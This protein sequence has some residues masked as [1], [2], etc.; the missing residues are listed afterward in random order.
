MS[1]EQAAAGTAAQR[2]AT[3]LGA[4]P[5]VE[6]VRIE[7]GSLR[8]RPAAATV[9]L[10]PEPG[11]LLREYL[12]NWAEV[13]DWV[14]ERGEA[15]HADDLDLSG[16]RAS[17]TGRPFP[18]AHMTDW[19]ERTVELVLRARP[20]VVLELGC[21]TGLLLHRLRRHV[22]AYVGT[23]V[24]PAA[25]ARLS[26]A[27]LPGVAVLQAAAHEAGSPAVRRALDGLAGAGTRPDCVLLNSV[28]QHFPNADYLADV[29][30]EAI[31]L[32]AA[33]GTVVVGDV[34][35]FGLLDRY[36]RWLE[37][38]T[39]PDA[40]P[41]EVERRAAIRAAREE[42]F[43]AEPRLLAGIAAR[44]GRA[45]SMTVHAKTMRENTELTRYRYDAVLHVEAPAPTR[46]VTRLRWQALPPPDRLGALRA[47]AADGAWLLVDGIPNALLVGDADAVSGYGLRQALHDIDAAV[48]VDLADPT[49]LAVGV[50]AQAASV[51]TAAAPITDGAALAH[52]PLAPFL[53]RRLPE[54]LR[55]Y[56]RR[57]DPAQAQVE[58][59]VG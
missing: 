56:L 30:H 22:T 26:A 31:T 37:T 5:W 42:E 11:P 55:D 40:P 49:A 25:V 15:R 21:G 32:V 34:R 43:L 58:I 48:C 19:V 38:A 2:A 23:D 50:P 33:G 51:P 47:R 53:N 17:D 57:V 14:Y 39:D 12:G 52:E 46:D 54:A 59:R 3:S 36:C 27:G 45:V 29:V 9:A 20:R 1:V 18:T 8:V 24:S 44:A 13:Y 10:H 4:H 35:H 41:A 28:T 6:H 7:G 16:W